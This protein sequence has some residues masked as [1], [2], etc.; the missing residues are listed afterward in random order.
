M[1]KD[2]WVKIQIETCR[3]V[4]FHQILL[5]QDLNIQRVFIKFPIFL[6]TKYSMLM[7]KEISESE[8][9]FGLKPI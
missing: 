5:D 6:S 3:R 8:I 1:F 2:L 7:S 4:P 9:M